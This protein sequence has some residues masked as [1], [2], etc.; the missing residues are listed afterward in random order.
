MKVM[1]PF[2]YRL[3]NR[4]KHGQHQVITEVTGK[5]VYQNGAYTTWKVGKEHYQTCWNNLIVTETVG[6]PRDLVD[7]LVSSTT[8]QEHTTAYFAYQ[9]AKE[10]LTEAQRYAKRLKFDVQPLIAA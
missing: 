5:P 9:H 1:N 4:H 10:N 7:A 8:P 3:N 2:A 6:V